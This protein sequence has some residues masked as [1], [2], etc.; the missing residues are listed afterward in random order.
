MEVYR[1]KTCL[2]TPNV[3]L[4]DFNPFPYILF[5][6][7]KMCL[8]VFVHKYS[9]IKIKVSYWLSIETNMNYEQV[10]EQVSTF[11]L[12]LNAFEITGGIVTGVEFFYARAK[13]YI[14]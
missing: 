12:F 10:P 6:Y 11:S 1:N 3:L 14:Q 5:S 8:L 13:H 9:N 7:E 2:Y 4:F